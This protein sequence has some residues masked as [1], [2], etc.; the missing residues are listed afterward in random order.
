M[1]LRSGV[2]LESQ[3]VPRLDECRMAL[4]FLI[5]DLSGSGSLYR[6]WYERRWKTGFL[7][8]IVPTARWDHSE[9]FTN[10]GWN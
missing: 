6:P 4:P 7:M 2:W 8:S 1:M 10:T 9:L 5:H 3:V